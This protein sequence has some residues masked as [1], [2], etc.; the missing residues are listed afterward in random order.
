MENNI[1]VARVHRMLSC[2]YG[3]IAA[4]CLLGT[5]TEV[6]H[7]RQGDWVLGLVAFLFFFG[8]AALHHFTSNGAWDA[9]PWANT[10]SM[11]IAALMLFGFPIGT[12]IGVYLLT[13]SRW[14]STPKYSGDLTAGWPVQPDAGDGS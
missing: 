10:T 6:W 12:F 8:L 7:G 2:L 14:H 3:V 13:H 4:I 11:V 1:K 9:K 5:A